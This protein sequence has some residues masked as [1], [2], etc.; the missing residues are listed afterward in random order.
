[1]TE[2]YNEAIKEYNKIKSLFSPN[3]SLLYNLGICHFF[4]GE[5]NIGLKS[6]PQ[7]KEIKGAK[8]NISENDIAST[9]RQGIENNKRYGDKIEE[10]EK[11]K[12]NNSQVPLDIIKSNSTFPIENNTSKDLSNCSLSS[13]SEFTNILTYN[14]IKKIVA[15][16]ILSKLNES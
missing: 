14:I 4:I 2:K 8:R 5:K 9:I 1:M 11:N 16:K 12:N 7:I 15:P 13:N 3:P 6:I 10:P